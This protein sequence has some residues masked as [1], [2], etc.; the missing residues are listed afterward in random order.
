MVTFL[1]QAAEQA[2]GI[3]PLDNVLTL[4]AQFG[5][6]RVVLP[7]L[8]IFSLV[9]AVLMKTGVLGEPEKSWVKGTAATISLAIAF[10]VISSTPVVTLLMTL[11][12]QASFILVV[13]LFLLMIVMFAVPENVLS[14]ALDR[15]WL[16]P[17]VIVLIIVF[18][19]IIGAA[20]PD[21]PLLSGIAQFLMGN[22]ALPELSSDAVNLIIAVIVMF[23][24]P[25]VIIGMIIWSNRE[26]AGE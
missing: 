22:V 1:A 11:V 10:F 26:G 5:F 13:A 8:L 25:A 24:I 23:G 18:L 2:T 17:I 19:G 7:F 20:T 21:I 4:L 16:I 6:F 3:T 12:P 9:Y 15:K 14:G